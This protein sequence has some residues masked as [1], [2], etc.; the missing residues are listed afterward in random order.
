MAHLLTAGAVVIDVDAIP[1]HQVGVQNRLAV[2]KGAE[3][4][5]R[6]IIHVRNDLIGIPR[7]RISTFHSPSSFDLAAVPSFPSQHNLCT[8]CSNPN[9]NPYPIQKIRKQ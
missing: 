1:N 7:R 8:L 9:P 2:Y 5:R 6:A 3:V 4:S